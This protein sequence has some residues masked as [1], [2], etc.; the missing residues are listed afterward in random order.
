[1]RPILFQVGSLNFYSYGFFTAMGFL[2]AGF[3]IDYIAKQ[4]GL[5]SRKSP[6]YFLTD[7]LLFALVIA[8]ISARLAYIII[9]SLILRTEP[10]EIATQL[11]GGGFIFYAG[12]AAGLAALWWWL[13]RQKHPAPFGAWLDVSIIGL[14]A[15]LAVSEIGGYLNDGQVVHL[16]GLIGTSALA[17]L[18]YVFLSTT[19]QPGRVFRYA[20]FLLFLLFFFLGFWRTEKIIWY[21]FNFGQWVSLIG[22]I[23]VATTFR[24]QK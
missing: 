9:Y 7:T 5:L 13:R 3:V 2:A 21:G 20:L 14:F 12:L 16:A 4:R 17:I 11:L 6:P 19:K 10:L 18:N 15:G 8:L 1:M 24:A 23:S 22:M